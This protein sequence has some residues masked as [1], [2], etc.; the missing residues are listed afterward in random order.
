M[1]LTVFLELPGIV[2]V[3][4]RRQRPPKTVPQGR[5]KVHKQQT[6]VCPAGDAASITKTLPD[7]IT[8]PYFNL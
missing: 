3:Q 7:C 2:T 6:G 4:E 8:P 5:P 1:L